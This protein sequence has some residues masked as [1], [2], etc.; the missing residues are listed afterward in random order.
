MLDLALHVVSG[1]AG[2][3]AE[4]DGLASENLH[5]DLHAAL[6]LKFKTNSN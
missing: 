4:R 3:D 2:L 1:V 5:K 6:L